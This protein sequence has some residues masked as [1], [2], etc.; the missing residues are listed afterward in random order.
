MHQYHS[1]QNTDHKSVP[2]S[3]QTKFTTQAKTQ[4]LGDSQVHRQKAGSQTTA[5][6]CW[7]TNV[8]MYSTK[9]C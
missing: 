7:S 8:Y 5:S 6:G 2:T 3:T 4:R 1:G 9:V